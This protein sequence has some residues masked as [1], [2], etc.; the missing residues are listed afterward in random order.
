MGMIDP[1][2]EYLQG[3]LT[4]VADYLNIVLK[5]RQQQEKNLK[6]N[7]FLSEVWFRG[8]SATDY[9]N[10]LEPG[11]YRENFT[12]RAEVHYG[13]DLEEKRLNLEREMLAEFRILGAALFDANDLIEVYFNAQHYGMP[14]C[15]LDWTTNTLAGLFFAVKNRKKH[16]V[17]GEVFVMAASYTLPSV[18]GDLRLFS[19]V[20]MR[21]SRVKEGIQQSF[22]SESEPEKPII[23]PLRP[24][25]L[26]GRIMQQSSR[27]TLHMY[28]SE[29]CKNKTLAK[30]KV[31][32]SAKGT[33]LE[34]LY[35]LNI[36]EFTMYNNLDRLS[37][38]MKRAWKI[39]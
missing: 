6:D 37:I 30:I 34:E 11:V 10:P 13:K 17:D 14:T 28:N 18:K 29:Q 21:H 38:D 31:P 7:K 26:P 4:N 36:N 19:V 5:W 39:E 9:P 25:N 32:S 3:P 23:I 16:G 1:P 8:C 33:I 15:L 27:F 35:H 2:K 22:W 20:S 12:K 24:D